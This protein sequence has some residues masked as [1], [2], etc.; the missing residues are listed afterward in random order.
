MNRP[1]SQNSS[2]FPRQL[3]FQL[4]SSLRLVS[5]ARQTV[6][7]ERLLDAVPQ[8]ISANLCD[9]LAIAIAKIVKTNLVG[10]AFDGSLT[11]G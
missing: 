9:A 5:Q 2:K 6:K 8:G 4:T 3:T 10:Q 7:V 1:G 11:V